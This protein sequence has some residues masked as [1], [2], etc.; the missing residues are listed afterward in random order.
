MIKKLLLLSISCLA[1]TVTLSYAATNEEQEAKGIKAA[2]QAR[3]NASLLSLENKDLKTISS[4]FVDNATWILPDASTFNGR[5]EIEVGAKAFFDSYEKYT[6]HAIII[7]KLIV[8]SDTEAQTYSHVVYDIV[9]KGKKET[10]NNPFA[11]YWVK[12][13][14]GVWRVAYEINADGVTK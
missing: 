6:T 9:I 10:H 14:D 13:S 2:L 11:D 5:A 4:L 1:F 8:I 12:G 7:D 3:I